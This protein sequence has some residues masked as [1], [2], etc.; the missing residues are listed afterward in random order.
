[1][2]DEAPPP[3]E[4]GPGPPPGPDP[5]TWTTSSR[6]PSRA[7][8]AAT[9]AASGPSG[10]RDRRERTD[11]PRGRGP[12]HGL[13][14]HIAWLNP[15]LD[16]GWIPPLDDRRGLLI[17]RAPLPRRRRNTRSTR[18]PS[19]VTTELC[20]TTAS[21][22]SPTWAS[23]N[24]LLGQ[25]ELLRHILARPEFQ[26]SMSGT[27]PAACSAAPTEQEARTSAPRVPRPLPPESHP[28]LRRTLR[29]LRLPQLREVWAL[30]PQV[31]VSTASTSI[32]T[33]RSSRAAPTTCGD[34][35]PTRPRP[36][37]GPP[38]WE[39]SCWAAAYPR[40]STSSPSPLSVRSSASRRSAGTS[41]TSRS[42]PRRSRTAPSRPARQRRP[43]R[44]ARST[45]TRT[46]ARPSRCR[47]TTRWS[48][49]S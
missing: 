47:P 8:G 6:A 44:G 33:S 16:T 7:S 17:R 26:R 2:S 36:R 12:R 23:T 35:T 37:T 4:P 38:A 40:T 30:A 5:A 41:T 42:R 25:D 19:S 11:D 27:E 46:S 34:R 29:Q 18:S 43:S 21:S 3:P 45:R 15:L 32:C 9:C 48:C 49:R 20:G 31:G 39:P 13:G 1:M 28:G 14:Q 24:L 22:G 10:P